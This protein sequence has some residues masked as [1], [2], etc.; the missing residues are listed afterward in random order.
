[1]QDVMDGWMDGCDGYKI[2]PRNMP[3]VWEGRLF[4]VERHLRIQHISKQRKASSNSR[5]VLK[6]GLSQAD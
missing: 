6:K 2:E 3:E 5:K 4:A 1:M